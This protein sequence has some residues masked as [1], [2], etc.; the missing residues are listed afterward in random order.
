MKIKLLLIVLVLAI[1]F[2]YAQ[3]QCGHDHA[4]QNVYKTAPQLA[5][6]EKEQ[7]KHI[8]DLILAQKS[9]GLKT[10]SESILRV[11][12]VVHIV[13]NTA[14]DPGEGDHM[15]DA[16][17]IQVINEVNED[18]RHASA[19]TFTNPHSGVNLNIELCLAIRD[20]SGQSTT[21]IVRHPDNT[22]AILN[23]DNTTTQ[24][25][26]HWNTTKYMNLYIV[27]SISDT[28]NY[29]NQTGTAGFAYKP[30]SHGQSYDG[31]V[32]RASGFWRGLL[33]HEIGHYFGLDHN[34]QGGCVNNDCTTDGDGI[35]D[36]PPKTS[37]GGATFS[38]SGCTNSN[39]CD[40]DDDD[41]STNNPFRP[42]ANGG[43]GNIDDG[44]ENYMDYSGGC[45]AAFTEGQKD[46]M[47]NFIETTRKS[48]LSSDGCK[49]FEANDAILTAIE[50]PSGKICEATMSPRIN[51]TNGGS[52][53]LTSAKIQV[54]LNNTVQYTY[55]YS[56]SLATGLSEEV[57]LNPITFS[58]GSSTLKID[59]T[60]VNG[61]T[62]E[63]DSDN[64]K[65]TAL[66]YNTTAIFPYTEDFEG[67]FFSNEWD[68]VNTENDV[69]WVS[70]TLASGFGTGSQSVMLDNY[71]TNISSKEHD[72]LTSPI[73]DLATLSDGTLKF[74]VAYAAYNAT[75]FD[76]LK[77]HIS[78]DCGDT[79]TEVY[80]KEHQT[81]ATSNYTTSTFLP[82]STQ[83]R[84]E[85]IDLT[86]YQG[87]A[88]QIGFENVPGYGNRLFLDNINITGTE[89]ATHIDELSNETATCYVYPNPSS[90]S[91]SV[92]V[93][94]QV[95]ES[96]AQVLVIDQIGHIVVNSQ[97]NIAVGKTEIP[98][99]SQLLLK[100]TYVVKI[101][102]EKVTTVTKF[103]KL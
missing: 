53:T 55:S 95:G 64:E 90:N 78:S 77:V 49:P 28:D 3:D 79:W 76:G 22:L 91:A 103:I 10:T 8:R 59:I 81:L 98:L 96:Q 36:T 48:L 65:T 25:T 62:D 23:D 27:D 1:Q 75:N 100:G 26:Y 18:F 73:I 20:P 57:T 101:V 34:F 46:V 68:I 44:N 16:E 12:V 51:L 67:D 94:S 97:Y 86:T 9:K 82:T 17:I 50:F 6:K 2:G 60:E 38:S 24:T 31:G 92:I 19:K 13:H 66:T 42:V 58:Q 11:P 61:S 5:E 43:I 7:R 99:Q 63:D 32:F 83:W 88:I 30:S 52:N 4:H 87:K 85:E 35:C 45:W 74:D 93:H 69:T 21:G 40:A 15:T 37:P 102:G 71:T 54:S 84:T 89:V 56:G 70:S 80:D 47:R 33:C 29:P 41:V 72:W 14:T 39:N